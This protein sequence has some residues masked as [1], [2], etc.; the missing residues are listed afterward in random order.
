[1]GL[2][3]S[4][5]TA[6]PLYMGAFCI[7]LPAY[8]KSTV[9]ACLACLVLSIHSF[10]SN[11]Q[12]LDFHNTVTYVYY[13]HLEKITVDPALYKIL[14][15][16]SKEEMNQVEKKVMDINKLKNQISES[17]ASPLRW[18]PIAHAVGFKSV[19]TNFHPPQEASRRA[20]A[21]A[22]LTF[23]Y[24]AL[25]GYARCGEYLVIKINPRF[26]GKEQ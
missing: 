7:L 6:L 1:M 4:F 11:I 8:K 16:A 20:Q 18:P 19:I 10:K 21:Y 13:K 14:F 9:L 24:N 3:V 17:F 22:P 25:Y 15:I 12:Y 23:D 5:R 2:S 26:L